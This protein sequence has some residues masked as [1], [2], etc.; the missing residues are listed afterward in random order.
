MRHTGNAIEQVRLPTD[1]LNVTAQA[2]A[3]VAVNTFYQFNIYASLKPMPKWE[4][5]IGPDVQYII[6]RSPALY[7]NHRGFMAGLN[8]NTSYK[9]TKTF[10]V[11]SFLYASL[12]EITIQ[13]TGAANLYYQFGA[14]KSFL[15]ERLDLTVNLSSPFN[16]T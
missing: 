14:K 10:T 12:P 2:F 4:L 9:L 5:S 6:R 16:R 3:N 7:A 1:S 11:Q 15:K 13:G 8:L